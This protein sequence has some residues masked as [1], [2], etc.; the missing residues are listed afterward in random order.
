[1]STREAFAPKPSIDRPCYDQNDP[2]QMH[3]QN[4]LEKYLNARHLHQKHPLIDPDD[5]M[6]M[7]IHLLSSKMVLSPDFA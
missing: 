6:T 3:P 2:D 4:K 1:M 5:V 7:P